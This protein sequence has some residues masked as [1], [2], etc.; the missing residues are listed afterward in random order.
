MPKISHTYFNVTGFVP[1]RGPLTEENFDKLLYNC[2]NAD[3]PYYLEN[4][5]MQLL[6]RKW[7]EMLSY[8]GKL[9]PDT[10]FILDGIFHGF[11]VID[12]NSDITSY[13]GNNYR[14][15][16]V[17]DHAAKLSSLIDEEISSGKMLEVNERPHCVHSLGVIKKKH[18]S[19]IRPV[20]DCSL[21]ENISVNSYMNHVC[22][23]FNY[24]T[25]GEVVASIVGGTCKFISTL[26]LASAYRAVPINTHN[27]QYFGLKWNNVYYVDNFLC[28]G[29]KSAPYIFSRLTDAICRYMRRR[30][31]ICFSYLDDIICLSQ[32]YETGVK[33]QLLLISVVRNLGF[34][35]AWSKIQSPSKCCT[36]LGIELDLVNYQ[37]RL[38]HERILRLREELKFWHNRKKATPKQLEILIGHL[39]HCSRIIQ[40]GTLYLHYLFD[41]LKLSREKKGLN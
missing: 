39:C 32:D 10:H 5:R 17:K 15:C 35:V 41:L 1:Y 23:K 4:V 18:S 38:P 14:S 30:N 29:I 40:G 22:D 26:D 13:H 21:P 9:D 27:R 8:D 28:F 37:M 7:L 19:K 11:N 25:V 33:D 12:T 31:V 36:Y 24:V 2:D 6:P 16:Y 20:T 3:N 34:Y